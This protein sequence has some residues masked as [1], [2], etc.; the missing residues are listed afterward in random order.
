MK[1]NN[2]QK[3]IKTADFTVSLIA[4]RGWNLKLLDDA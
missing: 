4:E 3:H 2:L 1:N